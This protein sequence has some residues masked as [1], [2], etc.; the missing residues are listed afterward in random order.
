MDAAA[1]VGSGDEERVLVRVNLSERHGRLYAAVV[2]SEI[3]VSARSVASL[4][5]KLMAA[6]DLSGRESPAK[7]YWSLDGQE[8]S[9]VTGSDGLAG[10]QIHRQAEVDRKLRALKATGSDGDTDG[11]Q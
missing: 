10:W 5:A 8:I 6:L 11:P 2:G 4:R 7:F 3:A 1:G 9:A